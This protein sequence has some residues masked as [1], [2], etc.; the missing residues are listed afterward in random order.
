MEILKSIDA[1][2]IK[3][4]RLL[5]KFK[6]ACCFSHSSHRGWSS[7]GCS[8]RLKI[9]RSNA[10]A[11]QVHKQLSNA[12]HCIITGKKTNS[13]ICSSIRWLTAWATV[14]SALEMRLACCLQ[15]HIFFFFFHFGSLFLKPEAGSVWGEGEAAEGKEE[16]KD[17]REDS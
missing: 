12:S 6:F 17:A 11:L 1:S 2:L 7:S 10:V 3:I 9:L 8:T 15:G 4:Q 16:M 13:D 5:W 14:T